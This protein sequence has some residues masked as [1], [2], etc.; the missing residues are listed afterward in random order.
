MLNLAVDEQHHG[1]F[2]PCSKE[3]LMALAC[4]SANKKGVH[5][6][7]GST[8]H[9]STALRQMTITFAAL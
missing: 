7:V 1:R 9:S 8:M 2:A 4:Q 6:H 5:Q 3:I